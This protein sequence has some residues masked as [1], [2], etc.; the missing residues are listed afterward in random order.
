M[1]TDFLDAMKDENSA[2]Q[3]LRDVSVFGHK[4]HARTTWIL[5]PLEFVY[6]DKDIYIIDRRTIN[7]RLAL[8]K[9]YKD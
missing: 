2:Y 3:V 5:A 4:Y 1:S 9:K 6:N 8:D 7:K